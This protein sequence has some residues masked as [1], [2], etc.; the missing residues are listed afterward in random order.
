VEQI[1]AGAPFRG[2]YEKDRLQCIVRLGLDSSIMSWNRATIS[3]LK[4]S[5]ECGVDAVTISIPAE[6]VSIQADEKNPGMKL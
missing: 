4:A 5:L 3:D 6:A 2:K 1:E